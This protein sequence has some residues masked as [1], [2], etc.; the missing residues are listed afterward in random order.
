MRRTGKKLT[1]R[2]DL[3][4]IDLHRIKLSSAADS[5]I[6]P[7]YTNSGFSSVDPTSRQRRNFQADSYY[8]NRWASTS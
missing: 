5:G 2:L 3:L 1:S 6:M 8:F 4:P 7:A